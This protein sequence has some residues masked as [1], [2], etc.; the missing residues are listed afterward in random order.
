MKFKFNNF[1]AFILI[2]IVNTLLY[3]RGVSN[4]FINLDDSVYAIDN[5]RIREFSLS[6][7]KW[8]FSTIYFGHYSPLLWISFTLDHVLFN[9]GAVACHIH[10][11]IIHI[12]NVFLIF[13]CAKI[14]L[15]N[16]VKAFISSLVFS[17]LALNVEPIMWVASRKDVL[18]TS[19][20]LLSMYTYLLFKEET[21]KSNINNDKKNTY[22][23]LSFIFILLGALVK[24]SAAFFVFC[25]FLID[26]LY[27]SLYKKDTKCSFKIIFKNILIKVP[28][29]L[30]FLVSTYLGIYAQKF[31]GAVY[32]YQDIT[33]VNKLFNMSFYVVNYIR[34]VFFPNDLSIMYTH[35]YVSI[36]VIPGI[37][38]VILVS[39]LVII[40][41]IYRKKY[42][43]CFFSIMIFLFMISPYLQFSQI[44]V[45]S[46]ADRWCY[47]SKF[48]ILLFLFSLKDKFLYP[49]L[50]IITII[51]LYYAVP[52]IPAW[53]SDTTL[54]EYI[55]NNNYKNA[56]MYRLLAKSYNLRAIEEMDKKKYKERVFNAL[57]NSLKLDVLDIESFEMFL[58]VVKNRSKRHK[59]ILRGFIDKLFLA[60]EK[61]I[62]QKKYK[63]IILADLAANQFSIDYIKNTYNKHPLEL[64]NNYLI[65]ALKSDKYNIDLYIAYLKVAYYMKIQDATYKTIEKLFPKSPRAIYLLAY[66]ATAKQ[67]YDKVIKILSDYVKCVPTDSNAY[68]MLS[69]AYKEKKD[70]KKAKFYIKKALL[71][72]KNH[73]THKASYYSILLDEGKKSEVVKDILSDISE[74]NYSEA[75]LGILAKI[76]EE[77]HMYKKAL[78][79]YKLALREQKTIGNYENIAK[80]YKKLHL[81]NLYKKYH[82]MALRIKN[83]LKNTPKEIQEINVI[84][85][86][87]R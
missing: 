49:L 58:G 11:I 59:E 12:L 17:V 60:P 63:A 14:F 54:Y 21:Y 81:N 73:P 3:Y 80:I 35:P 75:T 43:L 41:F 84:I 55:V 33:I 71:S 27:F 20:F 44:G 19:F 56:P 36:K 24:S 74:N 50:L 53:K 29:I 70:L 69:K 16:K 78:Y 61:T 10:N 87:A 32:N 85:N 57:E 40:T 51:N 5:L 76:Y 68:A 47:L 1:Y 82:K 13:L 52:Y 38:Y 46:M 31:W 67:D 77:K 66:H 18:H 28:F 86:T 42:P 83:L 39:L 22:F 79:I 4:H 45:Q 64:A 8:S 30:L 65:D 7:L 72:S 48:F 62:N 2:L 34:R 6:N 9:G 25:T 15:K 26:Y 37:F 23:I